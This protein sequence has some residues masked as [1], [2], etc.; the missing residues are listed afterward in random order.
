MRF[1]KVRMRV[2]ARVRVRGHV[3]CYGLFSASMY[4]L[5][6]VSS[7]WSGL[8]HIRCVRGNAVCYGKGKGQG[9]GNS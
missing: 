2:R 6:R 9:E 5:A 1:V 8:G 4:N 3:V 7:T